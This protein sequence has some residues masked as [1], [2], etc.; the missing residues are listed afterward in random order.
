MA[1][2]DFD[3][4]GRPEIVLLS[5]GEDQ[6]L[7]TA[8]V[9]ENT[10]DRA[11]PY[12][13]QLRREFRLDGATRLRDG[14]NGADW[15]ADGVPDL[16][17][18]AARRKGAVIPLGRLGGLMPDRTAAVMLDYVAHF[19]PQFGMADFNGDGHSDLDSFGTTKVGMPGVYIWLQ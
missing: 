17:L 12:D 16:V 3:A 1:A 5:G 9:F 13:E 11:R 7:A 4:D 18:S 6:S 2:A 15:N 10:G 14:P 8:R 19:A